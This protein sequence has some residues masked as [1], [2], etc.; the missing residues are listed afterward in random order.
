MCGNVLIQY[1]LVEHLIFYHMILNRFIALLAS[2]AVALWYISEYMFYTY[3]RKFITTTND[4]AY[5]SHVSVL[6]RAAVRKTMVPYI[7]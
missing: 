3:Y 5:K 6:Y 2:G 4:D 7:I 1:C